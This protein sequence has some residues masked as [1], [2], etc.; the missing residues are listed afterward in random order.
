MIE[1]EDVHY[2]AGHGTS[3]N[4]G[5][6]YLRSPNRI[7]FGMIQPDG[8]FVVHRGAN[9]ED[10]L[11]ALWSTSVDDSAAVHGASYIM[12]G[13]SHPPYQD[14][15]VYARVVAAKNDRFYDLWTSPSGQIGKTD[16]VKAVVED[17][18]NFC[19]Y[20]LGEGRPSS[21]AKALW[22]SNVTDPVV[23]YDLSKITYD[24][25]A[26]QILG[27]EPVTC[28]TL[29]AENNSDNEQTP[30]IGGNYSLSRT[31]G[32]SNA[33]A[34][35]VGIKV[36]GEAGVPLLAEGKVEL[37]TEVQNTYTWNGSKTES[38]GYTFSAPLK[39]GPHERGKVVVTATSTR[40]N[41][42]YSGTGELHFKSGARCSRRIEGM[43]EGANGHSVK[44]V[45]TSEK[46]PPRPLSITI[47]RAK[48]AK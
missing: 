34:V 44:A 11:D 19:I 2:R 29:D 10:K 22:K 5:Y 8:K 1:M 15:P 24:L 17:D 37:S 27:S 33:L 41:V 32:W 31:S 35:K 20:S 40:I 7:Y 39:L 21:A 38:V 3:C 4:L 47:T 12:L 26:V 13:F 14:N 36:T 18:G 43:Y 6:N 25:N 28:L 16:T 46:M 48:P 23:E 45:Y 42:P 30:T 9:P